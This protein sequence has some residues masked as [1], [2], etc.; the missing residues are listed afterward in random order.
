MAKAEFPGYFYA[1]S[2]PYKVSL[3]EGKNGVDNGYIPCAIC[4]FSVGHLS[5]IGTSSYLNVRPE[6]YH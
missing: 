1:F 6:S 5:A 2:R 4:L 3:P